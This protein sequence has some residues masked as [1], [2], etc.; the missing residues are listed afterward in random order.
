MPHLPFLRGVASLQFLVIPVPVAVQAAALAVPPAPMALA[1]LGILEFSPQHL[2]T[3]F[4][5]PAKK[6][7]FF[8][9]EMK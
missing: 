7:G 8:W 5:L 2:P 6:S 9:V 1:H 4:I 3:L